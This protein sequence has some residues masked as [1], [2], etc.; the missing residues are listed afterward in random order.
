MK[1]RDA[2]ET[3]GLALK[4][5]RSA[6]EAGIEII[7][8]VLIQIIAEGVIPAEWQLSTSLNFH[9]G[10]QDALEKGYF[11][12]LKLIDQIFKNI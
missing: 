9:K 10:K 8:N 11:R 5:V 4:L 12:G 3:S 6:G 2:A 1:N 7:T